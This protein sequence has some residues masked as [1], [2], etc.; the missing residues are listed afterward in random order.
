MAAN[1]L[2]H[3][4]THAQLPAKRARKNMTEFLRPGPLGT[5][6]HDSAGDFSKMGPH[7]P[8]HTFIGKGH[9]PVPWGTHASEGESQRP[10]RGFPAPARSVSSGQRASNI[11]QLTS[12]VGISAPLQSPS[13]SP[14]GGN[15]PSVQPILRVVDTDEQVKAW[16]Q[17]A[18]SNARDNEAPATSGLKES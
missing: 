13:S 7:Q 15:G 17:A 9:A 18:L 10:A 14:H 12:A 2:G 4:W 5:N 1:A 8:S 16:L 3:P 6:E 11:A